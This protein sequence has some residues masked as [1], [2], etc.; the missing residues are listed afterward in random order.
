MT[1]DI[2]ITFIN[3]LST[4]LIFSIIIRALMSWVMPGGG[5]QFARVLGDITEPL[6]GPIRRMLPPAG[7]IDFSPIVAMILIQLLNFMLTRVLSSAA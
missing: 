3:I 4:V 7:G 1:I 6:L 5:N 2:V